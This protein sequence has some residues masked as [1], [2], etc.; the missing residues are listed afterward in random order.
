VTFEQLHG[1]SDYPSVP[2]RAAHKWG[3]PGRKMGSFPALRTLP[4]A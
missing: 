4:E 3:Y 1:R 2:R